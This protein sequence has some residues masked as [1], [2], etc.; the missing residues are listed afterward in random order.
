M[1]FDYALARD[2]GYLQIIR[3]RCTYRGEAWKIL[4]IQREAL[5]LQLQRQRQRQTQRHRQRQR[6]RRGQRQ[7]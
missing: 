4:P 3:C 5:V 7:Q 1:K 2:K 6:Q